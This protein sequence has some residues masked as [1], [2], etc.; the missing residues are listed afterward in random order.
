MSTSQ[1]VMT[2]ALIVLAVVGSVVGVVAMAGA[3]R[4][5]CAGEMTPIK[6][7][8]DDLRPHPRLRRR[9]A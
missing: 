9:V 1:A 5:L 3:L 8:D 7:S 2:I 4:S 6:A